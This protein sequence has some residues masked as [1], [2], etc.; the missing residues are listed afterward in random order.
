MAGTGTTA[1][2]PALSPKERENDPPTFGMGERAVVQGF[3]ARIVQGNL[4][5]DVPIIGK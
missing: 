2:T 4:T 3:K 1:L 5:L